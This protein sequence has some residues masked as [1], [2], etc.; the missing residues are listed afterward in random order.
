M[1]QVPVAH[2]ILDEFD[3]VAWLKFENWWRPPEEIT[4]TQDM[5]W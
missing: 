4:E 5:E 3:L 1:S 2:F